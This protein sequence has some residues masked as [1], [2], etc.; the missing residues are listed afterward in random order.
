MKFYSFSSVLLTIQ[1]DI[2]KTPH[3]RFTYFEPV[4]LFTSVFDGVLTYFNPY[5]NSLTTNVPYQIETR[6]LICNANQ[7]TGFY[8][9]RENWSLMG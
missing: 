9:M 8:R 4:L 1:I 3:I 5:I 6:E 2:K 7:L